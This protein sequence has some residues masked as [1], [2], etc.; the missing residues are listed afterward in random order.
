[1]YDS[2]DEYE[3]A[4]A[5]LEARLE[6][7]NGPIRFDDIPW[8]PEGDGLGILG[9]APGDI[10]VAK[11]KLAPALRR[12][13]PDKW[14]RILDRV[15]AAEKVSVMDQARGIIQRLLTEKAK[16]SSGFTT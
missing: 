9:A 8:P 3:R 1:V 7:D 11:S 10:E 12:W 14:Q 5:C 6:Q 16:L 13:H 2:R 4:W 15:P